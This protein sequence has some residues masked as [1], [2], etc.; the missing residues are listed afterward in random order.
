MRTL[1][2]RIKDKHAKL[3]DALAREVNF[4]WNFVNELSLKHIQRTGKFFSGY[5]LQKYTDGATREGLNLHSQTVQAICAEYAARRKQFKKAKLRWRTSFGAR[6]SLG[7]IP[8][9]ASGIASKNGQIR[10]AGHYFSLWDSYGLAGY[11]LGSGSFSQDAK[12]H[13]YINLCAVPKVKPAH[14]ISLFDGA[15]GIDLGLKDFA[16]T[17]DGAVIEAQQV[18]RE[19][20]PK[21]AVAQRANKKAR[22]KS[23]HTKIANRRNDFHHKL[24]TRLVQSYGAIFVG[25]VNASKLA[26][27]KMAKSVFDAGWSAFRTMLQYKGDCA[28]VWFEEVNEAYSS[29]T[30]SACNNRTGPKGREGLIIREW[31]CSECETV[32][33][34]DVN[35][36][37][38]ILAAGHRRLAAGIPVLAAQAAAI[39]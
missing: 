16:V 24:S 17:S 2:L 33:H 1:R 28:G 20:E 21:L 26:K 12:G 27:T 22:V 37:T 10:Y 36:A 3:L 39:G 7:W 31:T 6:K 30:C 9:K 4:V 25:N 23:I 14:Q 35:A 5:D 38:N 11:D 13:W 18:Y 34:R 29:Q 19:L 8:F 32:H 15:V